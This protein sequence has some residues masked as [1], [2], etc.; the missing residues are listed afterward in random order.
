MSAISTKPGVKQKCWAHLLRDVHDLRVAH[1]EDADVQAWAA[2]VHDVYVRAVAWKQARADETEA[3]RQQAER[4]FMRESQRIVA[5]STEAQ[6][7]H[8]TLSQR[9]AR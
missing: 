1:V 8:R 5:P 3:A 2:G 7:P 6:V 9:M 4:A